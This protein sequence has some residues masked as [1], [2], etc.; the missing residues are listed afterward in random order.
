MGTGDVVKRAEA[1]DRRS[2]RQAKRT[3]REGWGQLRGLLSVCFRNLKLL[4]EGDLIGCDSAH[5]KHV[6]S[7]AAVS[8]HANN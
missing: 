6:W 2:Q 4:L 3:E 7:I 5:L 1:G 8:S